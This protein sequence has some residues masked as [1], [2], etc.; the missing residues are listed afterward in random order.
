M[1]SSFLWEAVTLTLALSPAEMEQVSG[2]FSWG[3][4]A[5]PA[6]GLIYF[7]LVLSHW[8]SDLDQEVMPFMEEAD[9]WEGTWGMRQERQS[10]LSLLKS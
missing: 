1:A 2:T 8:K 3:V 5:R 10:C 9:V 6:R 4:C 7:P